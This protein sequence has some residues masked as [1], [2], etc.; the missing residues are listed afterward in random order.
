MKS[1]AKFF[2]ATA[3]VLMLGSCSD[4]LDKVP[5]GNLTQNDFPV[6]EDQAFLATNAVYNTLRNWFYH[7]GGYPILDIMS[8][9]ARKGSNPTDQLPTVGPYDNFGITTSQDG[10]DRWWNALYEGIKRANV[11]I[12]KVPD[13]DMDASLRDRYVA[14]A[15]FLRALYYFDLARAWGGVPLV[16]TLTPDLRLPRAS[17]QETYALVIEDLKF[18]IDHLPEQSEL[19][20]TDYGRATR[21]AAVALLA[22]VYLFKAYWAPE[23]DDYAN[24][25]MYAEQVINS[26]QYTLD[27]D[28]GHTFSLEGQ[29]NSESVFEIGAI[30]SEGTENGGN[31]YAN[32]QGVRGTPNRGWGFNRP[33][34]D[35]MATF[36]PDDP[37]EDA[38]IIFLGETLDG[39]LIQGDALTP[40]ETYDEYNNLIEI[41][42][43][44][45]KIWIPGTG[46][47][48]QWGHNRRLIRYADVLLMAAEAENEL[49][50]AS[51]ALVYLNQVRE[52]ARGGNNSILPDITESSQEAL[53]DIILHERRAELAME[54]QRFWDLVRSGKAAQVLGPLGFIAGKN[55]LLPIPQ[56][57]I[58]ISENSLTQNPGW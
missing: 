3:S 10:L 44:N 27:P 43:Y 29:Y 16:T 52:R 23:G 5:Q 1:I 26:N 9:D 56:S 46:T 12:I 31:Q 50:N 38:T 55:E 36:E 34:L 11:V 57:Q 24:A 2:V 13:I 40:D 49:G 51:Q 15:R 45:Q 25:K 22:K 41:E 42:C 20:A 21:G 58:D 32:N 33:S 30:E 35:L 6:N 37:R 4:F 7:S 18:A 53:R 8:D 28:F 47:S 39:V 19:A 48:T 54:G 17:I 14:E